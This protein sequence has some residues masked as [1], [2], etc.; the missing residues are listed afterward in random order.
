M[1]QVAMVVMVVTMMMAVVAANLRIPKDMRSVL[2]LVGLTPTVAS[3]CHITRCFRDAKYIAVKRCVREK[4]V[5]KEGERARIAR[6]DAT[7]N[8]VAWKKGS[9]RPQFHCNTCDL[10][11]WATAVSPKECTQQSER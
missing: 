6:H 3:E 4:P 5:I 10:R 1:I 8:I 11:W 2:H 7:L 9:K